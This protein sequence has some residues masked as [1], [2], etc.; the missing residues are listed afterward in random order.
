M[1]ACPALP[2]VA[3]ID[4]SF[5]AGFPPIGAGTPARIVAGDTVAQ[6]LWT[7][8][9]ANSTYAAALAIN[10]QR[11]SATAANTAGYN[12]RDDPA[13][14]SVSARRGEVDASQVERRPVHDAE[15]ELPA[16]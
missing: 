9:Q 16:A 3:G 4:A 8:I 2:S 14:W 5:A 13:C 10:P 15:S 1:S 6:Q 12:A 11:G 7:T